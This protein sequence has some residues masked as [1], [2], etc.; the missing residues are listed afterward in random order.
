[1]L[2]ACSNTGAQF[3]MTSGTGTCTVTY[4]QAGNGSYDPATQ[5]SETVT[6][7]KAAQ[8]I[9][10][11]TDAPS[12]AAYNSSFDVDA[13][14]PGGA[15]AFAHAGQCSNTGAHFTMTSGTGT[16]TVTFDQAGNGNYN[17]APQVTETVTAQK[18]SQ[19]ITVTTHAPSTAAYNSSF[20]VVATA[21]AGAIAF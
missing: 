5:V 8:T 18:A 2:G 14:A 17:P 20:D 1:S 6:A 3:T 13:S 10:V 21:P 11:T 12:T 9:D 19:T 7:V 4:N 15:I 16:C